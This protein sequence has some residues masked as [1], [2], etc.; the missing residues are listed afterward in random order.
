MHIH[1][2]HMSG[3]GA[4]KWWANLC[5]V[6]KALLCAVSVIK[7]GH[8]QDGATTS[9]IQREIS[10]FMATNGNFWQ[11]DLLPFCLSASFEEMTL[12]CLKNIILVVFCKSN[13][14]WSLFQ[15]KLCIIG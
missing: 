2:M 4:L 7:A 1:F 15:G 8:V 9:S 14:C 10:V 3:S 12:P 13:C 5:L 6:N 11:I